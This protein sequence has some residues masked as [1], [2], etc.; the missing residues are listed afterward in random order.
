MYVKS[1]HPNIARLFTLFIIILG[2]YIC[3]YKQPF[4]LINLIGSFIFYCFGIYFWL[5]SNI[6]IT[7]LNDKQLI[8]WLPLRTTNISVQNINSIVIKK[9]LYGDDAISY[10]QCLITYAGASKILTTKIT[11]WGFPEH[12][13]QI[14]FDK[15]C[16]L[17]TNISPINVKEYFP[18]SL[19]QAKS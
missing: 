12:D 6:K 10:P 1:E 19:K 11:L 4:S 2:T 8:I 14:L 17:N 16:Y 18:K 3:Y 5:L 15:L 9:I 7:L 13:L